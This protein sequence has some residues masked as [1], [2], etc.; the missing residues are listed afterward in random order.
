MV[1]DLRSHVK[2]N[3][4]VI[5]HWQGHITVN[6]DKY[7]TNIRI[8]SAFGF[9]PINARKKYNSLLSFSGLRW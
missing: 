8:L 7:P 1:I 2:V 5:Y 9:I 4:C 3:F 6:I